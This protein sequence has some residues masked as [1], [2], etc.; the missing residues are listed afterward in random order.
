MND[1]RIAFPM[2]NNSVST[3]QKIDNVHSPI[4]VILKTCSTI[5]ISIEFLFLYVT[6]GKLVTILY[7]ASELTYNT[8]KRQM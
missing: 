3:F 1:K 2:I 5:F 7:R 4:T 6:W 8:L